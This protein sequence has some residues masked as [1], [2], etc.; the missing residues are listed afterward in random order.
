MPSW[1]RLP[2]TVTSGSGPREAWAAPEAGG[3]GEASGSNGLGQQADLADRSQG[4]IE[5]PE[6]PLVSN[7]PF[8]EMPKWRLEGGR[9]SNQHRLPH[10]REL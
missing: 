9:V 4:D 2:P 5:T 1:Q 8:L 6:S 3:D 10:S 7:A